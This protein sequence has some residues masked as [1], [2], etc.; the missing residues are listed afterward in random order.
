LKLARCGADAASWD[1]LEH[2]VPQLESERIV[3]A[4]TIRTGDQSDDAL[5]RWARLAS[6]PPSAHG[7]AGCE[8]LIRAAL[9]RLLFGNRS[10]RSSWIPVRLGASIAPL[11]YSASVN[12]GGV[13]P[14]G[15]I[16]GES[17][18][19]VRCAD[20]QQGKSVGIASH[21]GESR[22]EAAN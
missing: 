9:R 22:Y 1:A 3:L 18:R 20:E 12:S 7:C 5:E 19:G 14:S 15:G 13:R 17:G 8:G 4:L 21:V 11:P 6:R 10:A 16:L 2:I